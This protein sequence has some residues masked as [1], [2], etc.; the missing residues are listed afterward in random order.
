M[1]QLAATFPND[2]VSLLDNCKM[3]RS[4]VRSFFLSFFLLHF[5]SVSTIESVSE[6]PAIISI[7][8]RARLD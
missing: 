5:S 6:R 7:E 8:D 3:F 4:F 1:T 2:D